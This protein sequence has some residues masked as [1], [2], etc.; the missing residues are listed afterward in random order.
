MRTRTVLPILVIGLLIGSF[1]SA[2]VKIGDNPQTIDPASVLELESTERVLVIT[3]VDSIQMT[4]I[5]PSRGALVYNTS[6]DCV[7]YYNG[8]DWI[9]LCGADGAVGGLTTDPIVNPQSTIVITPTP[10]GGNIEIAASSINSSQ[11]IDGGING[12]D[13]QNGSIGRGKLQNSSVDR[14]KLA[15][16]SVGPFAIDNDSIDLAD[17]NNITGFIRDTDLAGLEASVATN[18]ADIAADGDTNVGNEIQNL[19][20]TGGNQLSLSLGGGSVT[21]PTADGSDTNIE[22]GDNIT[23]SGNG[24]GATPYVIN[25]NDEV[26]DDTE[27]E[28]ITASVVNG[29]TL[30]IT[31]GGTTFD[32]PLGALEGL[33]GAGG[34]GGDDNQNLGPATLSAANLLTINIE[35]GDAT[36]VDLSPLAGGGTGNQTAAQVP[37]TATPTNYIA[38]T[39]DVEAHLIGIDAALALGGG[40]GNQNLGEVLTQGN[41]GNASLIKNILNPVDDQDAATKSYVDGAIISGGVPLNSGSILVGD[42]VNAAQPVAIS[43]D[44]TLDNTGA[45]TITED[46]I[47]S[48]KIL[49]GEVMTD[50]I[51]NASV[52]LAKIQ[53]LTPVPATDQMLVTT[54]AGDVKW[55]PVSTGG[56]TTAL[57][58]QATITG[59]GVAGSEFQVADGGINTLQLADE[60]VTSQKIGISEIQTDH[61]ED[62]SITTIKIKPLTPAPAT[63]QMLISTTAGDVEWAQISTG[64]DPTSITSTETVTVTGT[65]TETD[66]YELTSIGGGGSNDQNIQGSLLTGELLTIGIE[67]GSSQNVDLASFATETELAAAITASEA[68]DD[69]TSQI[70]ELQAVTSSDGSVD[71]TQ[72]GNDYDLRVAAGGSDAQSIQGSLLTG[73]LLTIGIERGSSQNVDLASFATE[74]ELA[75]AITASEALDD[76]TSQINELQAV[77]SSDGS[78]DVTQNGNDYD[79]RVAEISGGPLG[80]IVENSIRQG[81]IAP[82][83]IG[84][85]ELDAD[86]VGES[87]L[88]DDA[89]TTD[90]IDNNTI[91]DLDIS[92]IAAIDGLKINPNFGAQVISTTGN[93]EG[94]IIRATGNLVTLTGSIFKGAFNQHTPDYV[95]QK[96][97]LGNSE[98]KKSY[99]FASLEEI[100]GFVKKYHHLPG[101][102]SAAQVKEDGVW[103]LGASNLQNLEKIEELF[104]HTIE[105]EK[106]IEQL[107]SEKETLSD[108]LKSLRNDLNEIKAMLKK[109]K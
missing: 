106:K 21:L 2:Q 69:D 17:F 53:P 18:T 16:N 63:N 9:N 61:I 36:S 87:E 93:I 38:S 43:G 27:N 45:L 71:V 22:A 57:A 3:R 26:D 24:T 4:N 99:H 97:F 78:V 80:N 105:Q 34:D 98:L 54:T 40:G 56:G 33:G 48:L 68:L 31:E 91:V 79:L 95:F 74:T 72:N 62:F 82:D 84:S 51:A 50:D 55:T 81:D 10:T 94:N 108:E 20:L 66:P 100:E 70:N 25:A 11:I 37:V 102:K 104:L 109:S 49:N 41:D 65:G 75:A 67:R 52:T 73:E 7:F 58:D 47:T 12:I 89:V 8:T 96:Y 35:N 46:V 85:S 44:A 14:T 19:S 64:G 103:D 39:T 76:D 86:S 77:T 15:E 29:T 59:N 90:K 92:D 1:A 23:I 6:A 60:A 13:I 107:Q 5:N 88:K 28:L 42:N 30:T 32:I 101:I 83:A